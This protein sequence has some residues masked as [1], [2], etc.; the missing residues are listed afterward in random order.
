[1]KKKTLLVLLF[2]L[3]S[4]MSVVLFLAI[5]DLYKEIE[6][7]NWY[8]EKD[9][10][11]V[12]IQDRIPYVIRA[13]VNTIFSFF[14]FIG[15]LFIAILF[16]KQERLILTREEKREYWKQQCEE[17]EKARSERKAKKILHLNAKIEKLKEKDDE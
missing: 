15:F 4:C 10:L 3:V 16:V 6:L 1:M 11:S 9:V 2:S 14:S 13:V 7:I 12:H 17:R 8:K 5:F